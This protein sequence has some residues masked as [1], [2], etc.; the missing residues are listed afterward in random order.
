MIRAL[1]HATAALAFSLSTL[2]AET[3]TFSFT[4]PSIQDG[5]VASVFVGDVIGGEVEI[6]SAT[7][8]YT[9]TW[10][11][12]TQTLFLPPLEF[13]LNLGNAT[14]GDVISLSADYQSISPLDAFTYSGSDP[15]LLDWMPGDPVVTAGDAA[16]FGVDFGSGIFT[17]F[18]GLPPE[19]GSD[20]VNAA[21]SL[22]GSVAVP[23]AVQDADGDGLADDLD[24]FP[25]SDLGPTVVLL[26]VDTGVPNVI[27]GLPVSETGTS[28]ADVVQ[29]LHEAAAAEAR[30]HGGHVSQLGKGLKTLVRDGWI[31]ERQRAEILRVVAR[32]AG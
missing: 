29:A 28:L 15:A 2:S 14:T 22:E 3:L 32:S 27:P 18:P 31:S 6:D 30:N 5:D 26:G 19:L 13:I 12:S 8:D 16:S 9:V 10:Y 20:L 4:D 25:N 7:G 21:G 24:P 1:T 17:L 23:P 11:A